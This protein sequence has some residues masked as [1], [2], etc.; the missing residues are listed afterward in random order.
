MTTYPRT[1]AQATAMGE[2]LNRSDW[3]AAIAGIT[4]T[5]VTGVR[6]YPFDYLIRYNAAKY[7]AVDSAHNVVYGGVDGAGSTSGDTLAPV[8]Q[9]CIDAIRTRTKVFGATSL[10]GPGIIQLMGDLTLAAKIDYTKCMDVITVHVGGTLTIEYSGAAGGCVFDL[11]GAYH[12]TFDGLCVYVSETYKPTCIFLLARFFAAGGDFMSPSAGS[13]LFNNCE[14]QDYASLDANDHH[15]TFYSFASETNLYLKTDIYVKCSAFVIT[16]QNIWS[17]ASTYQTIATGAQSSL[18]TI[19]DGGLIMNYYTENAG[20]LSSKIIMDGGGNHVFTNSFF[21]SWY[22]YLFEVDNT[23]SGVWGLWFNNN[24]LEGKLL[25]CT[26]AGA[27]ITIRDFKFENSWF[28]YGDYSDYVADGFTDASPGTYWIEANYANNAF[29]GWVFRGCSWSTGE[30]YTCDFWLTIDPIIDFTSYGEEEP[31]FTA[32][33][34]YR[35]YITMHELDNY[36]VTTEVDPVHKTF[37][38]ETESTVLFP[39][40]S[41]LLYGG[42]ATTGTTHTTIGTDYLEFSSYMRTNVDFTYYRPTEMRLVIIAQG[43]EAGNGKGIRIGL[44]TA[45][46]VHTWNGN[47][48]ERAYTSWVNLTTAGLSAETEMS[49]QGKGCSG[50]ED[51][52]VYRVELQFR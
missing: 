14:I 32:A 35:G 1:Y 41:Y 12:C 25:K 20:G 51:L 16:T 9:A 38:E 10:Y 17:V 40:A 42:E 3:A 33:T 23:H 31:V 4:G 2:H 19:F 50:T 30:T 45:E 26:V 52:T 44:G 46:C 28:D 8:W 37:L 21:G 34:L 22:S 18:Q 43:S 5:T 48:V 47:A 24:R 27:Y 39:P 6:A 36:V 13:H 49:F 15:T 7:E 29:N 11:T